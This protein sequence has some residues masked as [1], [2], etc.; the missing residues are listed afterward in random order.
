MSQKVKEIAIKKL[1]LWTENP[2]DPISPDG[3]DMDVALRAFKDG[4]DKWRLKKLAKEM[5]S[6]YDFSELPTVVYKGGKPIVYDGNRRVLLAKILL[7]YFKSKKISLRHSIDIPK[8][9]PC[10]VTTE[11]IALEHVERKHLDAS[12]WLPLERDIFAF[13]YRGAVKSIFQYV[14]E[15]FGII[16]AEPELNQRFVK[17]EVLTS[18]NLLLL[19]IVIDED[20]I[21]SPYSLDELQSIMSDIVRAVK[22]KAITT[23]E[24]RGQL[25]KVMSSDIVEL[26]KC[27]KDCNKNHFKPPNSGTER[28]MPEMMEESSGSQKMRKPRVTPRQ[29]PQQ[30]MIFGKTLVLKEGDVNDLYRDVAKIYSNYSRNPQE[31]SDGFIAIVRMALRLLC[32]TARAHDEELK[33]Y[34]GRHFESAKESLSK[35][36]ENTL[37][38]NGVDKDM[39]VAN[40]WGLK[41]I[42]AL[43]QTGAHD[44][45][46]SR[47]ES[48]MLAMSIIIGAILTQS[49]GKQ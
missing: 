49:H 36:D 1:V 3:T 38:S 17:D 34:I 21:K 41:K 31:Y 20:G 7:G 35:D 12:T 19:G 14:D 29:P 11:K 46:A 10:N 26:I 32:E 4:E 23:R 9:I 40:E 39:L 2:R 22:D 15:A 5:G 28:H 18:N 25:L 27:K 13:K 47:D 42:V 6:R 24:Y 37:F 44:Y 48:I 45:S 33:S 16:T 30:G 8:K 43:L